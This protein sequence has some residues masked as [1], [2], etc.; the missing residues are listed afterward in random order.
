MPCGHT[1]DASA[2]LGPGSVQ[3]GQRLASRSGYLGRMQSYEYRPVDPVHELPLTESLLRTA[4]PDA[5]HF[6]QEVLRWQYMDN[7]DGT[8]VGC[9]A[10]LEGTLAAHYVTIPMRA[11]VNGKLEKGL[12]SLNTATHP[13]HQGKGLFTKLAQATYERAAREGFGFVVGV[14]NANSTHGFIRKLGFSL[15]SPLRAMIGFGP[16]PV[17]QADADVQ[18]AHAWNPAS[19]AWRLRH[20]AYRYSA[21]AEGGRVLVLSGR[22]QFGARYILGVRDTA[23]LQVEL[24]H[25][26]GSVLRKVWIGLD[27]A[28]S[29]A[30]KPYVNIPMRFRPA[31]L[32]LIFKDLGGTG[33]VLDPGRVRFEAMDFDI[34]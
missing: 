8:V 19:V 27:P 11:N 26:P 33:R 2:C 30:G 18:F 22:K 21:K 28:M 13:A 5:V 15:V 1:R 12:L 29:W 17:R 32:N 16:L 34:L 9:N 6:T 24:P 31:P 23:E 14:A 3:Q 10:W 25:E 7:P 4:F 20:P